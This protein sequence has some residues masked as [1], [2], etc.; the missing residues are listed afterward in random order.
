[1]NERKSEADFDAEAHRLPADSAWVLVRLGLTLMRVSMIVFFLASMTFLV[2]LIAGSDPAYRG[3]LVSLERPVLFLATLVALAALLC[4]LLGISLCWNAPAGRGYSRACVVILLLVMV[5]AAS[6]VALDEL[7]QIY[8]ILVVY[9]CS[10]AALLLWVRFLESVAHF[11][12]DSVVAKNAASLWT[13]AGLCLIGNVI[14]V[15]GAI[16]LGGLGMCCV[17][18]IPAVP[19]FWLFWVVEGVRRAVPAMRRRE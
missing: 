10:V 17:F 5:A 13:V 15:L 7:A 8:L 12:H 18:V 16:G 9:L 4:G 14:F 11:F 6:S 1:V 3:P 2:G 19:Y